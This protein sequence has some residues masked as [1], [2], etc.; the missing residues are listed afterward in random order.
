M[1]NLKVWPFLSQVFRDK[2]PMT[3]MWFVLAAEQATTI[4]FA[5]LDLFDLPFRHQLHKLLCIDSP[6]TTAFF[7]FIEHIQRRRQFRQ[8]LVIYSTYLASKVAYIVTFSESSKLRH[9]IESDIDQFR[10]TRMLEPFEESF[11]RCFGESNGKDLHSLFFS[12]KM[13]ADFLC[14]AASVGSNLSSV[15]TNA[16]RWACRS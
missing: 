11:G 13:A 8:M 4:E 7:V 15:D 1:L 12:M 9:V 2:S 3:K 14:P 6:S 10:R 16:I 5:A